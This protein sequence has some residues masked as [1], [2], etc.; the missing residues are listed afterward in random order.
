MLVASQV[1]VASAYQHPRPFFD[2]FDNVTKW[3]ER[4]F[5]GIYQLIDV[6]DMNRFI[7]RLTHFARS[8]NMR[9]LLPVWLGDFSVSPR[10]WITGDLHQ[11]YQRR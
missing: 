5:P 7:E 11:L 10:N 6:E 8:S 3:F 4:D 1:T 9:A 2:L